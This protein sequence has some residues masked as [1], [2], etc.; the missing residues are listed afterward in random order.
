MTERMRSQPSV[1]PVLQSDAGNNMDSLFSDLFC[2]G[3]G[4]VAAGVSGQTV[5]PN[6]RTRQAAAQDICCIICRR[7][8]NLTDMGVERYAGLRG[9]Q[10]VAQS[11]RPT[12]SGGEPDL[13]QV[14]GNPTSTTAR[15]LS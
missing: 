1:L 8:D 14:L 13:G 10:D 6:A 12:T 2:L 15:S 3:T 5:D 4:Y 7:P 9:G 11:P